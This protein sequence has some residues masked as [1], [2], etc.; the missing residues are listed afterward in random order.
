LKRY[1]RF[2]Q[3][4]ILTLLVL[5]AAAVPAL[6]DS[7]YVV[8]GLTGEALDN[9]NAFLPMAPIGNGANNL[10]YQRKLIQRSTDALRAVGYYNAVITL[11]VI[12]DNDEWIIELTIEPGAPTHINTIDWSIEGEGAKESVFLQRLIKSPIKKGAVLNHDHY[13]S[14]KN[15]IQTMALSLG[16]LDSHFD[17]PRVLV[18]TQKQTATVLLHFITGPR[19][20]FGDIYYTDTPLSRDFIERI[21]AI[22]KGDLFS[23]TQINQLYQDLVNSRYFQSVS[24]NP[25]LEARAN[26]EVPVTIELTPRSRNLVSTGIGAS[27]NL[28]PRV[29]VGWE[30]PWIN[31][32]GHRVN[33]AIE[34]SQALKAVSA[35][36]QIPLD[37][38]LQEFF[39][40]ST[41]W[42][43]SQF[44]DVDIVKQSIAIERQSIVGDQWTQ[45]VFMRWDKEHSI[46]NGDRQTD[47]LYVPGGSWSKVKVRGSKATD[48][49]LTRGVDVEFSSTVWGSDTDLAKVRGQFSA[50]RMLTAP[51]YISFRGQ[52][53]RIVADDTADVPASM[54]FF[55]GGDQ[56]V[57]GF[58]YN[59]IGPED[60]FGNVSG[61]KNLIV[62]STEYAY[63]FLPNWRSAWFVDIGNAFDEP[64]PMKMSLGTGLHWL[65]P[66][67]TVRFELGYGFSEPEPPIRLHISFGMQ[68]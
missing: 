57:R 36:Y 9:V 23:S 68:L 28:G 59:S 33:S 53:G 6:A 27:T 2:S 17:N 3:R 45:T 55:T 30:K 56:S 52:I 8:K 22:K 54:R 43:A 67:G 62:G 35:R 32:R 65:T 38:P 11:D 13:E 48:W 25:D 61:G 47:N 29:K 26:G 18:N 41:A 49:S 24:L 51:H 16:Y 10:Q 37:R 4:L 66:I 40:L 42:T 15:D 19:Y 31:R 7:R 58:K 1:T 46:V 20:Y 50:S 60:A 44:E 39:T 21:S 14:L 34:W 12:P 64:T 63:G 5:V